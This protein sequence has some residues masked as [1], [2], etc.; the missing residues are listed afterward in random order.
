M[1]EIYR[2][3]VTRLQIDS[4]DR[5]Y[6]IINLQLNES[7]NEMK[8]DY[9]KLQDLIKDKL[10]ENIDVFEDFE[11]DRSRRTFVQTLSEV[12]EPN[13]EVRSY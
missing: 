11:T 3:L 9:H 5:F 8:V 10:R 7:E 2:N 6:D 4:Y 13:D 1:T 12:Q